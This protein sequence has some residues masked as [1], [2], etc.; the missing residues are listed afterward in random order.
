MT[1]PA[2][3]LLILAACGEPEPTPMADT[4][5]GWE[6]LCDRSFLEL[7]VPATHNSHASYERDYL[8]AAA[9][10]VYAI[11][12]Q[13]DDG[14]RALNVDIY[15]V[16]GEM[17]A[18]HGYCDFGSQPLDE[19]YAEFTDFLEAHP[20]E[21][22][23]LQLQDGAPLES[24]IQAF[25]DAGMDQQAWQ[26]DGRWPTLGEMIAADRRLLLVGR[27]GGELAPWYHAS[28]AVSFGTDYGYPSW[29]EMDCDANPD[30][31]KLFSLAHTFLDPIA[32][33]AL[34]EE[35]NPHLMERVR[36]CE[37]QHGRVPNLLGVDWYHHGDVVG[38]AAEL[39]GVDIAER[40]T[41]ERAE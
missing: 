10:H 18:C 35:G 29:Q 37:A 36:D 5:N 22:L 26:L 2:L 39:N 34:S 31:D 19:V 21:V 38:V 3:L 15:E 4:C 7:A 32:W 14:I 40:Q 27:G 13:L 6:A 8:E 33:E 17:V 11:P 1:R 23:W 30:P 20:R 25:V 16:D 24:T 41:P 9:N 28:S 12:T